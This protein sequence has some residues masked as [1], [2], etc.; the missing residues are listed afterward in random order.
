MLELLGS[1][2]W[3]LLKKGGGQQSGAAWRSCDMLAEVDLQPGQGHVT[4][5]YATCPCQIA[6][7]ISV[8]VCVLL[9]VHT[10]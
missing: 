2:T 8:C 5:F 4:G 1:G 10:H 6:E 7:K 3:L 9:S